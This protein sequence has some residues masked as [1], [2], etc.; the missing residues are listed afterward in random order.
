[1]L[2]LPSKASSQEWSWGPATQ[3]GSRVTHTKIWH[4][5]TGRTRP[6]TI[7]LFVKAW[8]ALRGSCIICH[9]GA[10]RGYGYKATVTKLVSDQPQDK[11][12]DTLI[13]WSSTQLL[14]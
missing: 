6:E 3:Q 5:Q 8:L 13:P 1:M 10:W 4:L 14:C 9:L 11:T 7:L 2:S 12:E